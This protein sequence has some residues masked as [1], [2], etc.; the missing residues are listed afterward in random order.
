MTNTIETIINPV[1][2]SNE[3]DKNET[4]IVNEPNAN[5]K[6]KINIKDDYKK[7][8]ETK[9]VNQYYDFLE[10]DI[11]QMKLRFPDNEFGLQ[12]CLRTGIVLEIQ[13]LQREMI[14]S[15]D[16]F[17]LPKN[18]YPG[19]KTRNPGANKIAIKNATLNALKNAAKTLQSIGIDK[20]KTLIALSENYAEVDSSDVMAAVNDVFGN[21][22][23]DAK[24]KPKAKK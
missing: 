2:D 20:Q 1:V 15:P 12:K 10:F 11:N 5:V 18:Y 22:P 6:A 14:D 3:S 7:I 16:L 21:I 8:T 17:E 13:R 9:I 4:I 23:D 24:A 19:M